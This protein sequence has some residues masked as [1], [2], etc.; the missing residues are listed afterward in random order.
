M[1]N[2]ELIE[3]AYSTIPLKIEFEVVS[4]VQL[5]KNISLFYRTQNQENF[6]EIDCMQ[7][8][9]NYFL[10][11]IPISALDREY[12]EYIIIVEFNDGGSISFPSI[13]P[14]NNPI[15]VKI[16]Q[17]QHT[18]FTNNTVSNSNSGGSLKSNALILSPIQN[19]NVNKDD[20]LIALSLFSVKEPNLKKV[21]VFLDDLDISEL[22]IIEDNL[23]TYIPE[24]ISPG[25]HNISI[26]IENKYGIKFE[27]IKWSF[28]I[29]SSYAQSQ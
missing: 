20:I 15:R 2:H 25:L 19:T 22:V 18:N 11:T 7:L 10:G 1:I 14:F 21:I 27:T 23:L 28:N 4:P 9:Q 12:V 3:N 17:F 13:D 26:P 8:Q 5:Y 24:D 6:F 16:D 29:A